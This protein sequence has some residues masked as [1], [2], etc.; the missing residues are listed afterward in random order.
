MAKI[1]A[2]QPAP[3]GDSVAVGICGPRT[4][5]RHLSAEEQLSQENATA[6]GIRGRGMLTSRGGPSPERTEGEGRR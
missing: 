6:A 2:R 3:R 1:S 4:P 5:G